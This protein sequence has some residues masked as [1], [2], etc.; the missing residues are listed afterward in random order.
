MAVAVTG[1]VLPVYHTPDVA[2]LVDV[3][4][5][6]YRPLL[7]KSVLLLGLLEQLHEKRV[8]N[9]FH[10]HNETLHLL[11]LA[12]DPNRHAPLGRHRLLPSAAVALVLPPHLLPLRKPK[13][14]RR[15]QRKREKR[16]Q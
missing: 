2:E 3:A 6:R 13:K 10:R 5:D 16:N 4:G 15:K 1:G 9:V 12:T 7:M 11:P 8:V 14:K